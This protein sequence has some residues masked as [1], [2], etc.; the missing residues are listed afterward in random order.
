MSFF[1][2]LGNAL[3]SKTVWAGI[4]TAALGA[5]EILQQYAPT[6]LSFVPAATPAGA[7]ITIALG[8]MTIYGRI[9][10]KQPLGPVIDKTIADSVNA[11][12]GMNSAPAPSLRQIDA[13]TAVVKNQP[14]AINAA[15]GK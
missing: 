7:A 13:V 8:A 6:I 12:S 15:A 5:G 4:G 10:A 11:I 2:S 9:R 3:K 14:G 1:K